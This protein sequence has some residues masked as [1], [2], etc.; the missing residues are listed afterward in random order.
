[1]ADQL[2]RRS[3]LQS[4]ATAGGAFVLAPVLA[5]CGPAGRLAQRPTLEMWAFSET[6]T[7]WQQQGFQQ[8][9]SKGD[10][11]GTPM[12]YGGMFNLNFLVL[13][14]GQMHDKLMIT[15]QAGQGGPDIA[16]VEIGRY[17]QFIKG[18]TNAFVTL[19]DYIKEHGG[20]EQLFTGSATDPWSWQ[21]T[22]NGLGNELNACAM[23]YR[24]DLY[25]KYGIQTPIKTY[26]AFAEAGKKLQQDSGGKV[27]LI[28]FD[29]AGTGYWWPMTL[30]RGGGYFNAKGLPEWQQEA[31]VA[32]AKYMQDALYK[33]RWALVAPASS[34]SLNAAFINGE[35]LTILG[36]SWKFSGFPQQSLKQTKGQWMVQPMPV[37]GNDPNS[38]PTATW[39]GTG[40]CVPRSSPHRD[41]AVDFVLWE[42]FTPDAVLLD[43]RKRQVWPTL[44]KAW[45]APELTAPIPWFNNQ[46]VGD[47][48]NAVAGKI[49]K[50][51]NS[52]F[53]PE[54]TDAMTRVG[55]VPA[56]LGKQ[57]P[58]QTFPAAAK[59]AESII[60]FES[61]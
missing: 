35:D 50:W 53:W 37:W 31:G 59:Q 43:Y 52:P 44:R 40:V 34:N 9:Y 3:F 28:E 58:A 48:I 18:G 39:G 16:D 49:P 12:R 23:A 33:D 22:I 2:S 14:Y 38:A 32:T 20:T 5:A 51:Y 8:Y 6:R 11:R 56:M 42:H 13:P 30:Q 61:A 41:M 15:T 10:G 25:E 60:S 7:A 21:G 54:G 4:A 55:W 45:S 27:H 24:F 26:E 36:P 46:K 19:N 57:D 1:M 29:P 47:V 17:S